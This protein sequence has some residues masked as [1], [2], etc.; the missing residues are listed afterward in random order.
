MQYLS[1]KDKKKREIYYNSELKLLYLKSLYIEALKLNNES[2]I[3]ELNKKYNNLRLKVNSTRLK[4]R[5]IITSR[6][7]SIFRDLKLSR[8][9]FR[10]YV[11]LGF[12]NGICKSSW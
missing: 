1:I 9:M 8:L 5:C 7:K 6:S 3:L 4:N 10:F 2:L 12:G 11:K